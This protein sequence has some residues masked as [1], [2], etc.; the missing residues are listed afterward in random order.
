MYILEAG[1]ALEDGGE[2]VREGFLRELDLPR[3]KA[4]NN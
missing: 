4:C 3:V 1:E 2:L